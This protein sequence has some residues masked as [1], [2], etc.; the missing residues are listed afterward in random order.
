MVGVRLMTAE[1][2]DEF[3]LVCLAP[4]GRVGGVGDE[5]PGSLPGVIVGDLGLVLELGFCWTLV[6]RLTR[7]IV[8]IITIMIGY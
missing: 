6:A 5:P 7:M 3:V 2:A 4:G 1:E 8:I